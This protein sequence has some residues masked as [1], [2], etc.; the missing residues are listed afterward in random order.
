MK[1]LLGIVVLGLLLSGNAYA[2]EE[3]ETLLE[4]NEG[5]TRLTGNEWGGQILILGPGTK[6]NSMDRWGER[7]K[8]VES[9]EPQKIFCNKFGLKSKPFLFKNNMEQITTNVIKTDVKTKY[10]SQYTGDRWNPY[11]KVFT[12]KF[13]M[14]MDVYKDKY[15]QNILAF[16]ISKFECKNDKPKPS[17]ISSELVINIEKLKSLYEE[18]TLTKEEFQKAKNILLN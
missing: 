6:K 3:K 16:T 5:L 2:D 14:D 8:F 1:K 15:T 17:E 12:K 9:G 10:N 7:I 11:L 4:F 18:G 13:S